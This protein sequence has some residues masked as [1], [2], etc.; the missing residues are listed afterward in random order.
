MFVGVSGKREQMK[1]RVYKNDNDDRQRGRNKVSQVR[2]P[3]L[4]PQFPMRKGRETT[5]PG[6]GVRTLMWGSQDQQMR[7]L[8]C[9]RALGAQRCL[10]YTPWQCGNLKTITRFFAFCSA[11]NFWRV[12]QCTQPH[13]CGVSFRA[14]IRKACRGVCFRPCLRWWYKGLTSFGATR[15][16]ERVF[17]EMWQAMA[18][19]NASSTVGGMHIS[20]LVQDRTLMKHGSSHWKRRFAFLWILNICRV[21]DLICLVLPCVGHGFISPG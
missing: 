16:L 2:A 17:G 7:Q 9:S 5:H 4:T 8:T 10:V 1:R 11:N 21:P 6:R 14:P 3:I 18:S 12:K 15:K 13:V 20:H 19:W